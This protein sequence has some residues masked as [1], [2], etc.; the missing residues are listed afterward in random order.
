METPDDNVDGG[1]L[2]NLG[3]TKRRVAMRHPT[4][5]AVVGASERIR[6]AAAA[7]WKLLMALF[8]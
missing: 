6:D 2:I 1:S 8:E 3:S 5:L 7:L 4:E